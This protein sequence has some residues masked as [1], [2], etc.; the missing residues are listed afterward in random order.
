MLAYRIVERVQCSPDESNDLIGGDRQGIFLVDGRVQLIDANNDEG[1]RA[2]NEQNDAHENHG[3]QLPIEKAPDEWNLPTD[4]MANV[5]VGEQTEE[6][7]NGQWQQT[8]EDAEVNV[9]V[10][11]VEGHVVRRT[12][13]VRTNLVEDQQRNAVEHGDDADSH[14]RKVS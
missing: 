6:R 3:R 2:E 8:D 5:V 13:E 12:A 1:Q 11:I 7:G 4:D 14:R 10:E 9:R